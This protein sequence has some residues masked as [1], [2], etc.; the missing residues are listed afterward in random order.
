MEYTFNDVINFDQQSNIIENLEVYRQHRYKLDVQDM[1]FGLENIF[2]Q[3]RNLDHFSFQFVFNKNS[4]IK[5]NKIQYHLNKP[6]GHLQDVGF[7]HCR[8]FDKNGNMI[9]NHILHNHFVDNLSKL[10]I[11]NDNQNSINLFSDKGA[12]KKRLSIY[13][14][15]S[16]NYSFADNYM[17]IMKKNFSFFNLYLKKY[18]LL[19]NN[20]KSE[21]VDF[22]IFGHTTFTLPLSLSSYEEDTFYNKSYNINK[23]YPV[24]EHIEKMLFLKL[25]LSIAEGFNFNHFEKVNF[26]NDYIHINGKN[27]NLEICHQIIGDF[28][29]FSQFFGYGIKEKMDIT[30]LDKNNY[31][32]IVELAPDVNTDFLQD[33]KYHLSSLVAR[34]ERNTINDELDVLMKEYTQHQEINKP[35]SL[36]KIKKR[37]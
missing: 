29:K 23:E 18:V 27:K 3:Y 20:K 19:N 31:L 13:Q 17:D 24:L 25:I 37:I 21:N 33:V 4:K 11:I 22:K 35:S 34:K 2:R 5:N 10:N 6:Y 12:R 14:Q 36:T 8:L 1:L 7:L 16:D 26:N 15:I 32:K 9:K 28:T 30:A